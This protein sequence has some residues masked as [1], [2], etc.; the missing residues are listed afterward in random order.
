VLRDRPARG[1]QRG[2]TEVSELAALELRGALDQRLSRLI[3]P[4]A[5]EL[6]GAGLAALAS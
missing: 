4:K 1:H 2:H 3:N 6:S 5:D